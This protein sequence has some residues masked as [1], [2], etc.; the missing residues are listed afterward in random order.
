M[1]LDGFI[2]GAVSTTDLYPEVLKRTDFELLF[3][4]IIEERVD[5]GSDMDPKKLAE[6]NQSIS[7]EEFKKSIIRISTLVEVT[8]T[9]KRMDPH[10]IYDAQQRLL[11]NAG[12][13][14]PSEWDE[15]GYPIRYMT[16]IGLKRKEGISYDSK[17]KPVKGKKSSGVGARGKGASGSALQKS[18]VGGAGGDDA[19]NSEEEEEEESGPYEVKKLGLQKFH[20]VLHYMY[21]HSKN[22]EPA[23]IQPPIDDENDQLDANGNPLIAGQN[24]D[25]SSS[26][27]LGA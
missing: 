21:Q 7:F 24:L 5:K 20:H 22:K 16:V 15:E 19:K 8:A 14:A 10:E 9:K 25:G 27:N 12:A 18:G 1:T 2:K 23:W 17:K 4:K 11:D 3:D 13:Q 6:Y 26:N